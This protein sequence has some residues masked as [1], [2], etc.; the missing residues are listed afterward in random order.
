VRNRSEL[1]FAA[2]LFIYSLEISKSRRAVSL[3]EI[4]SLDEVKNPKAPAA[5]RATDG[6]FLSTGT[7]ED[8]D[9]GGPS[10]RFPWWGVPH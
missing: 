5:I 2:V 6:A 1:T 9:S 8:G 3:G 7:A 10:S 4:K